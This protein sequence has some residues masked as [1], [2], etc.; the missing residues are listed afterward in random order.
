MNRFSGGPQ[1]P[2]GGRSQLPDK[3]EPDSSDFKTQFIDAYGTGVDA[4]ES[5]SPA[6][7]RRMQQLFLVTLM[8]GL[9]VGIAVASLAVWGMQ[10][11]GLFD[12]PSYRPNQEQPLQ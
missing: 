12:V 2:F 3:P 9:T 10:K 1:D 4:P 6:M 8:L 5:V 11:A 7:K